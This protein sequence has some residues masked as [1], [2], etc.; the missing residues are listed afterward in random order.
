MRICKCPRCGA[1]LDEHDAE[2]LYEQQ[3]GDGLWDLFDG[4]P[5]SR[6]EFGQFTCTCP[7]CNVSLKIH[8]G[9]VVDVTYSVESIELARTG[10]DEKYMCAER[11][12]ATGRPMI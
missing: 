1:G 10:A 5:N 9:C 4:H 12:P 11:D 2:T 7:S 3:V 6:M 8:M